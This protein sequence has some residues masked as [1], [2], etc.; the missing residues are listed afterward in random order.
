M[1]LLD[2][3]SG[4]SS[5]GLF[6]A[7]I[8]IEKSNLN[9]VI[10][11]LKSCLKI[12]NDIVNIFNDNSS[13]LEQNMVIMKKKTE[14]VPELDLKSV[15][16]NAGIFS[17]AI[18]NILKSACK[19]TLDFFDLFV[20]LSL[21]IL[22]EKYINKNEVIFSVP[23]I[24]IESS[25]ISIKLL[26][27][28]EI[29]LS[30][31]ALLL[32]EIL[33]ALLNIYVESFIEEFLINVVD[34]IEINDPFNNNLK[35][36][37]IEF[38]KFNDNFNNDK[39]M[40]LETNIDDTTPEII[41]NAME[42]ILKSGALDFTVIPAVMKKNRAGFQI[43]VLCNLK[44]TDNIINQLFK[45]TSTFGIRKTIVNRIILDRS[46]EEFETSLGKVR[47]KKGLLGNQIIRVSPEFD[48]IVRIS[49]ETGY[50]TQNIYTLIY[51][52]MKINID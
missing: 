44:D 26:R 13:T 28:K 9:F 34:V 23:K 14:Q 8:K 48:D 17:V 1:W 20:Y 21:L 38:N 30:K 7:L 12:E 27:K 46:I 45:W 43:Q 47:I 15:A 33:A 18:L 25:T 6:I 11:H 39:V 22:L 49:E 16:D 2:L 40:I 10:N 50:S 31:E 19:K 35:M 29:Y 51:K 41:A 4:I 52:E 5:I 24:N 3:S 32:P 37:I 36:R 42:H